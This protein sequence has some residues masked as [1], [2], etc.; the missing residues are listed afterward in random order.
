MI[1]MNGQRVK[2]RAY[3]GML[4]LL[5]A[6]SSTRAPSTFQ[7]TAAR[8]E[9]I[10]RAAIYEVFT[11]DF[12]PAGNFQG[13]IDGLDRIQATGT[14]V[15]WLMPIHPIGVLN[16]KPPLG[17][18][19]SV[20]DYRAINPDYGN[21]ADFRRLVAAAHARGLRVIIDWVPNHTAW[22]HV[23]TRTHP[24]RYTRDDK[25]AMSV[26]RDNDG[27]LTDWTDVADLDYSNPDL[28]A[29]MIADMRYWLDEF[30]IDGFRVD[31]AGFVPDAF[32][33]E[34]LPRLRAVN[35]PILL[36]AEWGDL[37]MHEL[38][39]DLS[40]GWD[41]YGK[42]K[43]VWKGEPASSFVEREIQEARVM[44][45]GGR[46]LRF[47]TNHDETA[48]DVPAITLFGGPAGA[49][50]AYV[51]MALLPGVPMLYNGQE[52]ESPQKLGLFVKEPVAWE[53]PNAAAARAFYHHI[54]RLVRTHPAFANHD[55]HAVHT[56]AGNDVISYRRNN[57]LVLANTRP[58][59][60]DVTVTDHTVNGARDLLYGQSQIGNVVK[61]SPHGAA[62]FELTR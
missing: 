44:P 20:T 29:A 34:A 60:I 52:V 43:A 2:S 55:L 31:V 54:I 5:A 33:R 12:S 3:V 15:I 27:K 32:W 13:V 62:I 42:L 41:A 9:W 10:A 58:R 8:P 24:A 30:G 38:G 45:A 40:Y 61:L 57:V 1:A 37:R 19:Y 59:A 47:T 21:A 26:A 7:A 39:Y 49:R 51:A 46:R 11:R 14:N 35:R 36:L 4:I 22:D 50:A 25:G 28:R 16:R 23:W 48:W 53:Q 18:S 17:S 6:C 56:N